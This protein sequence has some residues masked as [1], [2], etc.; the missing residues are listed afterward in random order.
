MC[1]DGQASHSP[2]LVI[3]SGLQGTHFILSLSGVFPWGQALQVFWSPSGTN[4]RGHAVQMPSF[5]NWPVL[6]STNGAFPEKECYVHI[7]PKLKWMAKKW[8]SSNFT[9]LGLLGTT[10][11]LNPI[12]PRGG[13]ARPSPRGYQ[14]P[15]CGG[16][17]NQFQI[18]W[19]FPTTFL[20]SCGKVIFHFFL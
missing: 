18:C 9:L 14:L 11:M 17:T 5:T 13:L 12:T 6:Q 15:F 8:A 16:C 10:P 4:P 1:V 20:L 2:S 19:L 3:S 7:V